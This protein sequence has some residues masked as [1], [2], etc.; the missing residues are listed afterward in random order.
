[1][2][3]D[4][5]SILARPLAHRGLHDRARGVIENSFAAA[6]AAVAA[7]Y[8]I[9]CDIQLS[10][11]G[12]AIVFHDET[13]DRLTTETGRVDTRSAATLAGIALKDGRDTI[14]TLAAFL[15]CIDGRVPLVIEI[16]SRFDGDMR[17]AARAVALIKDY[18][19]VVALKSFDPDIVAHCRS[20][21][22][23]C[24]LGL[25]GPAENGAPPSAIETYDFLSWHVAALAALRSDQAQI[26]AMSWTIRSRDDHA[27]ATR[28]NAQIVFET[29]DPLSTL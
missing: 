14:P 8:G 11:D 24:P 15:K 1:M 25:V 16:K 18:R 23:P 27:R 9:E 5:A 21:S 22:A 4:L 19:G 26:P 6:E 29:F 2:R 20:L 10:G 7:G 28:Y 3:A 13:L 12:E 17:L